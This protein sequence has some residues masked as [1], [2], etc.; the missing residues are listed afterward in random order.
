VTLSTWLRWPLRIAGWLIWQVMIGFFMLIIFAN[1]FGEYGI[2]HNDVVDRLAFVAY[3]AAT[4][5]LGSWLPVRGW[6]R[7]TREKREEGVRSNA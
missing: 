5:W 1:V 6:L 4:L 2:F 3:V 7:G